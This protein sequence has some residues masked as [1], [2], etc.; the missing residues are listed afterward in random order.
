MKIK[1]P[2]RL[3][4]ILL[5]YWVVSL[6][7]SPSFVLAQGLPTGTRV[8]LTDFVA[9]D[10]NTQVHNSS[11][12]TFS[13]HCNASGTECTQ[14]KNVDCSS[15]QKVF[16]NP[17][18][19]FS[20]QGENSWG[21][22]LEFEHSQAAREG[23]VT[24]QYLHG[25]GSKASW[26]PAQM[27]VGSTYTSP[28]E[29]FYVA[30]FLINRDGSY[31]PINHPWAGTSEPT[32][33]KLEYVGPVQFSTGI[34][35]EN[36][37]IIKV[38]D[39]PG[40][41]ETFYY[42]GPSAENPDG[43]GWIGWEG[44]VPDQPIGEY[45]G[46]ALLLQPEVFTTPIPTPPVFRC[47]NKPFPEDGPYRPEPCE[48]CGDFIDPKHLDSTCATTLE[49]KQN[50]TVIAYIDPATKEF[51]DLEGNSD[52]IHLC[53]PGEPYAYFTQSWGGKVELD[54]SQTEVPFAGYREYVDT[55]DNEAKYLLRY[56]IGS[57]LGEHAPS[58]PDCGG[59][60]GLGQVWPFRGY[61]YACQR[62]LVN[63]TGVLPKVLP[64]EVLDELRCAR[65]RKALQ[66]SDFDYDANGKKLSDFFNDPPYLLPGQSIADQELNSPLCSSR[67]YPPTQ[68]G[69][70]ASSQEIQEYEFL[71]NEHQIWQ[72]KYTAW[73]Q[74]DLTDA[75]KYIPLTTL[76]DAPGMMQFVPTYKESAFS[77]SY[78]KLA[79]PHMGGLY[80]ASQELHQALIPYQSP[81]TLLASNQS[82]SSEVAG[83]QNTS[84]VALSAANGT[85]ARWNETTQNQL[86][87]TLLDQ[88]QSGCGYQ[89]VLGEKTRLLVQG[90]GCFHIDAETQAYPQADGSTLVDVTVKVYS[91]GGDGHIQ[92]FINGVSQGTQWGWNAG[93]GPYVIGPQYTNSPVTIPKGGSLD[94]NYGVKIDE[95]G[96]RGNWSE[97]TCTLTVDEEGNFSTNCKEIQPGPPPRPGCY[98]KNR[99][100]DYDCYDPRALA[101]PNDNDPICSSPFPLEGTLMNTDY[102]TPV[103]QA[104]LETLA[105]DTRYCVNQRG[106]DGKPEHSDQYETKEACYIHC[107][108]RWIRAIKTEDEVTSLMSTARRLG[109]PLTPEEEEEIFTPYSV[110]H[111]R[112][113]EA[114]QSNFYM[115]APL[116]IKLWLPYTQT[117]GH[118]L[119]SNFYKY[120]EIPAP[121]GEFEKNWFAQPQDYTAGVFDLFR[122]GGL[123]GMKNY[124]PWEAK[125][126]IGYQYEGNYSQ[127]FTSGKQSWR[128]LSKVATADS[129]A[130]PST[131]E[132]YFPW[133]GG[134]QYAKKCIS[135]QVLMPQEMARQGYCPQSEAEEPEFFHC[136]NYP[137]FQGGDRWAPECCRWVNQVLANNPDVAA[138]A[139]VMQGNWQGTFA[140][141]NP[142]EFC[143]QAVLNSNAW[144]EFYDE[145]KWVKGRDPDPFG[146]CTVSPDQAQTP[147]SNCPRPGAWSINLNNTEIANTLEA[148][149]DE[150][151]S[152]VSTAWPNNKLAANWDLLTNRANAEGFNP[153]FL[154]A[155][156]IE[157]SGAE[158]VAVNDPLGCAPWRKK[159]L[160]ESL[161]C[162]F[163]D[164]VAIKKY[165]NDFWSFM[166]SYSSLDD[167]E[168]GCFRTNPNFP[169]GIR[170]VY[171]KIT[172]LSL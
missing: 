132:L 119:I 38:V 47:E 100:P 55:E 137:E 88:S 111:Y 122:P 124:E 166:L 78:A 68:P 162:F 73:L 169:E 1:L 133:L 89:E 16:I 109:Y 115:S 158:G 26:L 46:P 22:Q 147:A 63:E 96:D 95:C 114:Y 152:T 50:A 82:P 17:D 135:E 56:L 160:G 54:I 134:V 67:R 98:N 36:V 2:I 7:V 164:T 140:D 44:N 71:L 125:T 172:G 80:E 27:Q 120:K 14:C 171:N 150:I 141:T 31:T 75:W 6:F 145:M 112:Y 154:M 168:E 64:K 69:P 126:N 128:G 49:A 131:G 34:K 107:A 58:D 39:G 92:F 156:Y 53:E 87:E 41:G 155:L 99:I 148:R 84:E 33:M 72:E 20:I 52:S 86:L 170:K 12:E 138:G 149:K 65:I 127:Y 10:T 57:N 143:P 121:K 21:A 11:G 42:A 9:P 106:C 66:G 161:D 90:S 4:A 19:S 15:F 123:S 104:Q 130:S 76:K 24:F 165:R 70:N 118:Y 40:A 153:A 159:T 74:T 79:I 146:F 101:D 116:Q 93:S 102:R 142:E 28:G 151:L 29:D 163:K 43:V 51:K 83:G 97:I 59:F 45:D 110:W 62:K 167:L 32:T 35:V 129:S 30:G 25:D 18:G 136:C 139:G 5:A 91:D 48:R 13:T 105:A 85:P 103:S 60:L 113:D 117:V 108:Q 61:F 144:E 81:V 3:I 37:A 157:E 94:M 23:R 8:D 77:L